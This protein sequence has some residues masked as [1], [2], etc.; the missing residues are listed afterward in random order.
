MESFPFLDVELGQIGRFYNMRVSPLYKIVRRLVASTLVLTFV[1]FFGS[2]PVDAN[3]QAIHPKQFSVRAADNS[4]VSPAFVQGRVVTSDGRGIVRAVI[5]VMNAD[6]G[7]TFRA[8]T[9]SFGYYRITGLPTSELYI[10]TVAHKRYLF[11][12]ASVSFTLKEDIHGLDF[13]ASSVDK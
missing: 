11:L 13:T 5:T 2:T 10:L 12:D 9:S 8:Y 3:V 1:G 4:S 7:E 6:T